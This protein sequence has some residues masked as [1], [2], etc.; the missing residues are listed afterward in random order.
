[1]T[2]KVRSTPGDESR[3]V[4]DAILASGIEADEV[5]AFAHG[6]T[7]ATN[8]LLERSG[9]RTAL[10]TTEGFRDVLEIGRQNR[11]S[12]YD[13]TENGPPPLVAR[14]L[15][16]T[17]RERAAPGGV[18]A[19]LDPASVERALA[20][21]A[22]ADVEAVAICLLFAFLHPEHERRVGEAIGSA[23]P[24]VH[25][26]L[27]S[28]VLPEF[29]EYER[30]ATT[31]ADAY[32]AP[33]VASYLE[34]LAADAEEAGL[35]APDV[36]QSSGGVVA[37]ADAARLA[38][39]CV[40]SGPAAGAVGAAYVA[41]RSGYPSV[42]TFDMGGTSTDVAPVVDG[43]VAST[44]E[45]AVGGV[46]IRFPSVDVHSVSAG[47]GSIAWADEGGALRVGPRSAGAE[48]GPACYGRGGTEAAVTDADLFLGYLDDGARLGGE[49]VLRRE[50]AEEALAR[51]GERID[52]DPHE[53]ALGVVAVANAELVRAL[54]VI[55]VERGLDPREFALVAFGGAG[56]MHACSVAEE[57]GMT[58]VLVP[59]ASGVLSALGLAISDRRRDYVKPFR[60]PLSRL[61]AGELEARYRELEERARKDLD[62]CLLRRR[63]DLRYGGQA[64]ELT[65]DVDDPCRLASAFEAA[66]ERRYGY[67]MEGDPVEIVSVRLIASV[68]SEKLEL[69]EARATAGRGGSRAVN[70]DGE[71]TQVGVFERPALGVGSE[72]EGPA[73]VHFAEATCV[74]RPGWHGSVDEAGALVLARS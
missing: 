10:V 31:V 2:A 65:I 37:L 61:D 57:L 48:P 72:V 68:P 53:T 52:L 33:R 39:G 13:L 50:L 17:V 74:V 21:L 22:N 71:W 23:L 41:E 34:A 73:I 24:H 49:I 3:G 15:R 59:K 11:P 29:R 27:S 62:G 4:L 45:A 63:A 12:L 30:L 44:T 14:D 51:V 46:P 19:P 5:V 58:T 69:R 60:S 56:P 64:F 16:F 32:L 40:A 35:P 18:L 6:T 20:A 9:G 7:V 28:D 38:A 26:S 47:G 54:R 55:T 8:T 42:L 66:H 70:V 25:V 67:R 1:M 36:M 43:V